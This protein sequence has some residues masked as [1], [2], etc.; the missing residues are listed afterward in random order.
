MKTSEYYKPTLDEIIPGTTIYVK[1]HGTTDYAEC[2]LETEEDV[3]WAMETFMNVTEDY[4]SR[5]YTVPNV[6]KMKR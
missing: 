4:G 5:I 6:V 3:E 2:K 1:M